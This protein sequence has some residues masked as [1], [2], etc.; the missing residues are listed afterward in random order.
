VES[1]RAEPLRDIDPPTRC[2][3]V[4]L[5]LLPGHGRP[6]SGTG[7]P[8][9]S[10]AQ[11]V[12]ATGPAPTARL[13]SATPPSST[14]YAKPATGSTRCETCCQRCRQETPGLRC[15]PGETTAAPDPVRC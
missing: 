10:S 15:S 6:R 4:S 13:T 8:N 12:R 5:P 3:W 2:R 1:I 11:R 7:R 9:G 14:S